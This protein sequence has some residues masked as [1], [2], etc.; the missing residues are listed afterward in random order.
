MS[1]R[2]EL[3]SFLKEVIHWD[4]AEFCRSEKDSKYSSLQ[5]T[6]FSLVRVAADS[7]LGAIKLAIARVDG[8]L[9]TPVR[10]E[11][12]KVYLVFPYSKTV[13]LPTT[14]ETALL[15]NIDP[16]KE[17]PQEEEPVEIAT[18]S[19]RETLKKMADSP[20]Q[21]V[22]LIR[23]KKK[24]IEVDIENAKDG[25][26]V[27]SVIAANLLHLAIENNNFEAIQEVF[28]QIDGKLVETIKLLGDDLYIERYAEE[29]PYG[30]VKNKEGVYMIED[31]TMTDMWA[32]KLAS[33]YGK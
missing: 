21:V 23:M 25:P 28:D 18:M 27:K 11:F 2:S 20:R 10:F 3:G 8:N 7:K 9:E 6:V 1:D 19:L 33:K 5:A 29:A 32:Q 12:P 26:L 4:W 15:A 16:L 22:P 24:E 14:Q 30:S 17:A 13:T 31:R